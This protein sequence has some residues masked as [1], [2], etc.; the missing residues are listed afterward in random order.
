MAYVSVPKDLNKI[1]SKFAFGLT[2]SQIVHILSGAA[3]GVPLFF[4]TRGSL[5]NGPAM[6]ILFACVA[7]F[8][9]LAL[10]EKDGQPAR[11]WLYIMLRHKIFPQRRIYRTQNFYSKVHYL[12]P[13]P[14]SRPTPNGRN[15]TV[16]KTKTATKSTRPTAPT[17]SNSKEVGFDPKQKTNTRN[18]KRTPSQ[19]R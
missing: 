19:K 2:G 14:N 8:A 7:P 13:K 4:L 3:L 1:K 5:G 15:G 17:K 10:Y 6:L 16:A 18:P 12:I 11:K 9:F